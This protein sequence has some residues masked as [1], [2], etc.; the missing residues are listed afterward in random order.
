MQRSGNPLQAKATAKVS[1]PDL[2][3]SSFGWPAH[4]SATW[5]KGECLGEPLYLL[6][7]TFI[8]P[9]SVVGNLELFLLSNKLNLCW[10]LVCTHPHLHD[11]DLNR[12][13]VFFFCLFFVFI[14]GLT[15][16]GPRVE[17]QSWLSAASLLEDEVL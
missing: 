3:M 11:S 12:I 8:T 9:S 14:P 10:Y 5:V 6:P 16:V 4:E 2:L 13:Q 17:K 1:P 15:L 7:A